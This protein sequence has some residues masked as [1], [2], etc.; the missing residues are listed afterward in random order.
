MAI[1]VR[2]SN[3]AYVNNANSGSVTLPGGS[4]AGDRCVI[5]AAHGWD[6][7]APAGWEL[8]E[9]LTGTNINGAAYQKLLSAGDITAGSVTVSFGGTYYGTIAIIGFV[10]SIAG[11]KLYA[12]SRNSSGATSRVVTTASGPLTGEYAIYYGHGRG[13]VTVTSSGGSG[14]QTTSNSN[15]SAV[16]A[17]G[18]LGS[19]GAVSNTFSYSSAPTGDFNIVIIVAENVTSEARVH[20]FGIAV[21]DTGDPNLTANVETFGIAVLHSV[22]TVPVASGR[23]VSLM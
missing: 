19:S 20:T 2:G 8:I 9:N 13:N 4:A 23:R 6:V 17:G 11:H 18:V 12:A 3:L 22:D 15:A 7:V 21:L 10:G 1:S 5:M 14:L 16:L